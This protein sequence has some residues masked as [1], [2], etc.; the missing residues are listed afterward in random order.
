MFDPTH[1]GDVLVSVAGLG[2]TKLH[3]HLLGPSPE[4]F[5]GALA[6]GVVC[7]SEVQS[8]FQPVAERFQY[9]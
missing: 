4:P 6:A 7:G 9:F 2:S 3:Q 1:R 5:D 8:G